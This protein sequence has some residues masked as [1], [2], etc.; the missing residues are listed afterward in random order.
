MKSIGWHRLLALGL[1]VCDSSVVWRGTAQGIPEPGLVLYGVVTNTRAGVSYPLRH[2][3]LLWTITPPLGQ[4]SP[5]T[6]TTQLTNLNDQFSYILQIPFQTVIPGFP[7]SPGT[8][9]LTLALTTYHCAKVTLDE[10]PAT[11]VSPAGS[12]FTF[13]AADR[14]RLSRVDLHVSIPH[15]DS[16]KDGLP[17]YWEMAYFNGLGLDPDEDPDHDGIC[18]SEEHCAGTDPTDPQSQFRFI[19]VAADPATG[20]RV[21]WSSAAGRQYVVERSGNLTQGFSPVS[22]PQ[23]IPAEPESDRTSWTDV[24]ASGPGPYFYRLLVS[25]SQ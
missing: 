16:D 22:P 7:L 21:T 20:L 4:G 18:N 25:Y 6:L 8:L 11:I 9:K 10:Q 17:D 23:G 2:G 19:N 24:S 15:A 12:S 5:I 1:L 13:S 14:G 3:I